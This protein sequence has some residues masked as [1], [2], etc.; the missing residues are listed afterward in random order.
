MSEVIRTTL[1]IYYN[2]GGGSMMTVFVIAAVAYLWITEEK[3]EIKILF[4][5]LTAAIGAL[6]FFPVFA[7]IA[8]HFFLDSQVYYRL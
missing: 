8:M 2:Y 4:V 1:S 7:Y 3:K 6:F 5:Y